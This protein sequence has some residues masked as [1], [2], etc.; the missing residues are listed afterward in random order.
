MI[1]LLF[2]AVLVLVLA[3]AT[4]QRRGNAPIGDADAICYDPCTTSLTDTGVR[5]EGDPESAE[6][7]DALGEH[8]T[9]QL[10]G[11]LLRCERARQACTDFLGSLKKRGIY[12]V[13]E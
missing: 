5:W 10:A 3:G 2:A 8:T 11:R 7:W 13:E 1:R 12:R 6:T 4:C 9:G